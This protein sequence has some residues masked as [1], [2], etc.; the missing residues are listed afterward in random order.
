MCITLIF[1]TVAECSLEFEHRDLHWGNILIM[2]TKEKVL[3]YEISG[4]K[5]TVKSEGVRATIIDF[6][7]SRLTCRREGC[8]IFNDLSK[9]SDLFNGQGDYQYDIYRYCTTRWLSF[10]LHF[11]L[12]YTYCMTKNSHVG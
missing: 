11:I 3:K 4:K 1:L 10:V 6:T 12:L 8:V 9:D 7:L 2:D 5:F